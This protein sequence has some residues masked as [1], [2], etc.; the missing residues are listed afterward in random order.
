MHPSPLGAL[1]AREHPRATEFER[2]LRAAGQGDEA[3]WR[4]L[5]QHCT[6][7]IRAVARAHRLPAEDVEDVVQTTWLRLAE[8]IRRVHRPER[9]DAWLCTTARRECLRAL[10]MR[11]EVPTDAA[12]IEQ[13][14]GP[15]EPD[16]ELD[17]VARR[18][19][20]HAA[21]DTLPRHHAQLMRML[22]TDPAPSYI[23]I[24][25]ALDMP[26]GSIGPTRAR[27][28]TRLRR[29]RGLQALAEFD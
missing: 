25:A 20:M 28:L 17:G 8:N 23:E 11:R 19:A 29:H 7:R 1:A 12:L 16:N 26:I 22:A 9:V 27:C 6:S 10:R 2:L 21:L 13:E 4:S 5:V 24:A 3:A 14:A 15:A 18:V